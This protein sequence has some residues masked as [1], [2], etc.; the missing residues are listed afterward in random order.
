M[1]ICVCVGGG[2]GIIISPLFY[3]ERYFAALFY[4]L[5]LCVYICS[6]GPYAHCWFPLPALAMW[7][8][9]TYS[10]LSRETIWPVL[11]ELL[12]AYCILVY[13]I[14]LLCPI[15]MTPV[16]REEDAWQTCIIMHEQHALLLDILLARLVWH[17]GMASLLLQALPLVGWRKWKTGKGTLVDIGF[18]IQ[19]LIN[20]HWLSHSCTVLPEVCRKPMGPR[21]EVMWSVVGVHFL[22]NSA[23]Q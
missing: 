12:T 15:E 20:A 7:L 10:L 16:D 5:Q 14:A 2:G 1:Y 22:H 17:Y 8:G 9:G 3:P 19:R 4:G 18:C 21:Q 6:P 11:I 23:F 13:C